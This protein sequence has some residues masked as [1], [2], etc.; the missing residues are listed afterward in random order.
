MPPPPRPI[1]TT[2]DPL[3]LLVW[4]W[5]EVSHGGDH[6]GVPDSS[7]YP[8]EVVDDVG[9]VAPSEV[10]HGHADLLVVVLQVDAHV[11]LQLLAPVHRGVHRVLVENPTVEQAVLWDLEGEHNTTQQGWRDSQDDSSHRPYCIAS[12]YSLEWSRRYC[13][14]PEIAH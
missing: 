7:S 1:S 10:G 2:I 14:L 9:W 6:R 3:H 4:E 12:A 13:T 5:F 8:V 11:L